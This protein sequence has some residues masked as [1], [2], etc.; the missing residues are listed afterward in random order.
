MLITKVTRSLGKSQKIKHKE[1]KTIEKVLPA[2]AYLEIIHITSFNVSSA[3]AAA[4]VEE[5]AY[6]AV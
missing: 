6:L 1:S 5:H 4:S 2:Q 3:S